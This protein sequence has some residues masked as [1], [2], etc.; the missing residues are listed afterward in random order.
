MSILMKKQ[1]LMDDI[2][3]MQKDIGAIVKT[4]RVMKIT[5][6]GRKSKEDTNQL[7]VE[8]IK[9]LLR[10]F[11]TFDTLIL[12]LQNLL[13]TV[14]TWMEA[15]V[16]GRCPKFNSVFDSTFAGNLKP[17][18]GKFC[19]YANAGGQVGTQGGAARSRASP[20]M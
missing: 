1:K 19:T 4:M 16:P 3:E 12:N 11:L 2:L 20:K 7:S 14:V 17:S 15:A 10:T 9:F 5:P 8:H 18:M 6:G 13:K